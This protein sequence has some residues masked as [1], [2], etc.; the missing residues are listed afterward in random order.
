MEY[1]SVDQCRFHE[2]DGFRRNAEKHLLEHILTDKLN[3]SVSFLFGYLLTDV[4]EQ[5]AECPMIT[6]R[7]DE[8]CICIFTNTAIASP[9]SPIA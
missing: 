1:L 6:R 2:N 8:K 5:P 7:R 9:Q 3:H 4:A